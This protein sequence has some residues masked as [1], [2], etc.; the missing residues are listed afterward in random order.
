MAAKVQFSIAT[1]DGSRLGK[2]DIPQQKVAEWINFL[3]A[4]RQQSQIVSA[5]QRRSGLTLQFQASE[6]LYAYLGDRLNAE[7]DAVRSEKAA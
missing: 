7:A 4:P 6:D 1:V 3:I 5:E 2:L